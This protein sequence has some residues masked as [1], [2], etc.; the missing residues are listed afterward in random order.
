MHPRH[1]GQSLTDQEVQIANILHAT[2]R[3]HILDVTKA[4]G[5][6]SHFREWIQCCK[7]MAGLTVP[8]SLILCDNCASLPSMAY[9]LSVNKINRHVLAL[10]H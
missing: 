6:L 5:K 9:T 10:L 8:M 3:R 2:L 7:C 1:R 4:P